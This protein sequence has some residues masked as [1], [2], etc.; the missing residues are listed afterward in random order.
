MKTTWIATSLAGVLLAAGGCTTAQEQREETK[1]LS[2][3]CL[4]PSVEFEGGRVQ[5]RFREKFQGTDIQYSKG[6]R[7]HYFMMSQVV[8]EAFKDDPSVGSVLLGAVKFPVAYTLDFLTMVPVRRALIHGEDA[9]KVCDALEDVSENTFV[10]DI[11][12]AEGRFAGTLTVVNEQDPTEHYTRR[13]DGPITTVAV[14]V[15]EPADT[16]MVAL[17]GQYASDNIRCDV[18]EQVLL[19]PGA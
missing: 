16:Y 5:A 17:R 1:G 12:P 9:G 13:I 2:Y 19:E 14:P 10:E 18:D 7:K 4:A 8:D 11:E 15:S 3:S 6:C